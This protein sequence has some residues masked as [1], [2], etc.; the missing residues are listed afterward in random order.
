MNTTI[1]YIAGMGM[2]SALG[3]SLPQTYAAIKAGLSGYSACDFF[4]QQFK[5][6]TAAQIP[7][8]FFT[9]DGGHSN[10]LT[11]GDKLQNITLRAITEAC[12]QLSKENIIPTLLALPEANSASQEFDHLSQFIAQTCAPWINADWLRA[13]CAGRAAG[14]AAVDFAYNYLTKGSQDYILI[15]GADSYFD[16]Q[17]LDKHDQSNRLLAENNSDGFAPGEGA[18]FI[19]LTP[20]LHLASPLNGKIVAVHAPGLADEPGH[21][22]SQQANLGRG[23]DTAFKSA[24][25]HYQQQS[26]SPRP[27]SAIYS[28]MNGE[29]YWAREL[30]VARVRNAAALKANL[31]L[32]HPADSIG[33]LGAAS[34]PALVAL[35]ARDLLQQ[36]DTDAYLV[37]CSADFGCRSAVVLESIAIE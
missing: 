20:H 22:Y 14:L 27:I 10:L 1:F 13:L 9:G 33:D 18:A 29:R 19:L 2:V 37:S 35:A 4:N 7:D 24:L 5:P 31:T 32:H 16:Q 34:A 28:S 21:I 15:G 8:S 26:A 25:Q 11:Y 6:I 17:R 36:P 12:A 30:G 3:G 23:L